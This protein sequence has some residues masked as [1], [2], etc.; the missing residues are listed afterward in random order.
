MKPI[1][2][3]SYASNLM[4]GEL[5]S[6]RTQT[7]TLPH[8]SWRPGG[9][10]GRSQRQLQIGGEPASARAQAS[11][12]APTGSGSPR[13]GAGSCQQPCPVMA[14][15]PAALAE[16]LQGNAAG[17]FGNAEGFWCGLVHPSRSSTNFEQVALLLVGADLAGGGGEGA[18]RG[19]GEW[20]ASA[21]IAVGLMPLKEGWVRPVLSMLRQRHQLLA[22]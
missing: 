10:A 5:P 16:H 7:M 4:F 14:C 15:S 19:L 6:S 22:M 21:S 18:H 9:G 17:G 11:R 8:P 3:H 12:C 13:C 2:G 20:E 1:L